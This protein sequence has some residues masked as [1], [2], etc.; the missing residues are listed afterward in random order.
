MLDPPGGRNYRV[1]EMKTFVRGGMSALLVVVIHAIADASD[2][3]KR[4]AVN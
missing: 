2:V 4:H 1:G 3:V